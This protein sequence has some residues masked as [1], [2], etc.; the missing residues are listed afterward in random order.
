MLTLPVFPDL[1]VKK[2]VYE[3]AR[4]K[5]RIYIGVA[6]ERWRDLRQLKG[7]KTD[8]EL[9]LFL[10]DGIHH[11]GSCIVCSLQK[12]NTY[13]VFVVLLR[14]NVVTTDIILTFRLPFS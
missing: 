11:V 7:M 10:L 1:S 8:A 5:T 3:S 6:F 9:A 13:Q 12:I 4:S 2:R 14:L